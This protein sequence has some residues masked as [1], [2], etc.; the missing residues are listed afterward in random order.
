VFDGGSR[1][2]RQ[3]R[4]GRN[5]EAPRVLD[6]DRTDR[7]VGEHAWSARAGG[8]ERSFALGADCRGHGYVNGWRG[9]SRGRGDH[10]GHGHDLRRQ[11]DCAQRRGARPFVGGGERDD[12]EQ[13]PKDHVSADRHRHHEPSHIALLLT[14]SWGPTPTRGGSTRC[15]RSPRPQAPL[16]ARGAPPLLN[17]PGAPP[18]G[19][20]ARLASL[21][22]RSS[23][24]S[25][26]A[27]ALR[28]AFRPSSV[29]QAWTP[30]DPRS[31]GS[32]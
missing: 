26:A 15:A 9:P 5:T 32:R 6:T 13:G 12:D 24:L 10:R 3:W 29:L 1:R 4:G 30:G 16:L 8:L 2:R 27:G 18:P 28:T 21:A 7:R 19:A 14:C 23:G 31:S 22:R 17:A 20:A 25:L 11:H